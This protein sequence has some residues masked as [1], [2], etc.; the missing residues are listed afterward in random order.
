[1]RQ[2]PDD[3][4]NAIANDITENI[5]EN[6]GLSDPNTSV[7]DDHKKPSEERDDVTS[8]D[9]PTFKDLPPDIRITKPIFRPQP[10]PELPPQPVIT[11]FNNYNLE[12][13]P[14]RAPRI[15][16]RGMALQGAIQAP[17]PAPQAPARTVGLSS[18]KLII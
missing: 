5:G 14:I 9:I 7:L 2:V 12:P 13:P 11:E 17:A 10:L 15:I 6:N 3:I 4:I 18:R 8:E 16:P 1:M